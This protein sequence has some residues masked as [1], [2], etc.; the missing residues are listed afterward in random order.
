MD[1]KSWI[2]LIG[3]LLIV[4]VIC[5]GFWTAYRSRREPFRLDIAPDIPASDV[6]DLAL[7]RGE[8][9]NGGARPGIRAALGAASQSLNQG[10]AAKATD[11]PRGDQLSIERAVERSH[12]Q[13]AIDRSSPT[14]P[15][16]PA[17][18]AQSSE[19]LA[20]RPSQSTFDLETAEP[21]NDGISEAPLLMDAADP[22]EPIVEFPEPP[23]AT[24]ARLAGSKKGVHVRRT[25][26]AVRTKP[27]APPAEPATQELIVLNV[28]AKAQPF[29]GGDL[30]EMFLRNG[31]KFGEM[32]IFHRV[33][34]ASKLNQ[35]SIASV[36]EPGTF[37]LRSMDEMSYKG[38]CFFMRMPCAGQATKVFSDMLNVAEKLAT[39]LDGEVCDEQY[40]RLTR[41]STEHFRQRVAEFT[42]RHMSKRA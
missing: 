27:S 41:Q 39:K 18:S 28:L 15:A 8:L 34:P 13:R 10:R 30:L 6:D 7:L 22:V 16:T 21:S 23:T 42:R 35:F 26:P 38:L 37:D 31:I 4:A 29:D 2:L 32:N 19:K 9:P 24:K 5:H 40:N 1:I 33:D 36:T 12:L 3:S 17:N 20:A 14:N 25:Q 11:A